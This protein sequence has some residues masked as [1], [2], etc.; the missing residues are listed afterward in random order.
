MWRIAWASVRGH[1]LRTFAT[2]LSVVFGV[3]FV[4]G[5]FVF[6]DT[7]HA[8]FEGLF[9]STVEG[10]DLVVSAADG[11]TA[12]GGAPRGV[13]AT[14]AAELT[15]RPDVADAEARYRGLAKLAREDGTALGGFGSL[16]QGVDAPRLPGAIELRDGDLPTDDGE[17]AIDAASAVELDVGVGDQ[18]M[19]LLNGPAQPYR[20]S[21]IVEP[22]SSV[23]DLAGST[24]VVFTDGVAERL[25]G[26][27]GATYIAVRAGD[28]VD[29]IELRDRMA[30]ELDAGVEVRTVDE[31][32][33]DSVSQV[34]ESLGFLTRGLLVF[35]GAALL[36]GAIIIFNTFGITVAQRTREL[37]LVQAVG[38]DNRQIMRAVLLEAGIVGSIGSAA[39]VAVGVV[40]AVALRAL[41]RLVELPLPTTGLVIEPRTA[42]LGFAVGVVVTTIAAVGPAL[43]AARRAPVDALRTASAG[44]RTVVSTARV[45]GG[46][47]CAGLACAVLIGAGLDRGGL[48]ALA[49]G[50]AALTV[51]IVLL[52]P[53]GAGPLAALVGLPV[54]AVL[55]L[56]GRLARDNAVRNPGRT[57]ATVT[58]LLI[59]LGLV[60]FMLI[61]VSSFRHSLDRAIVEQLRADYQLQAVDQIGYPS[62]VTD[63]ADEIDG[64]DLVSAAKVARGRVNGADRTVFAIDARTLP[65]VY[66]FDVVEGSLERLDD[67]GVA[68]SKQ[69]DIPLGA[70]VTVRVGSSGPASARRV[71]ALTD[72]LHLP[73]TTRV[74]QALVDA[75][76]AKEA[77]AGRPDLVAFIKL[78]PDA[79]RAGARR[80]LEQ[81]VAGQPDVRVADTAELRAQVRDQTDRLLHLVIG[82]VL[83]SVVI[84]FVGV[85]NALGLSVVERSDELGLLQAL[86]MTQGQARQMVRWESVIITTVGTVV[87]VALGTMFGWLGVRVLREEG[88]SAFSIPVA[89]IAVAVIAMLVAGVFASV[90]PARRAS[91]VDVLHAV[92]TE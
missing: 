80:E 90:V 30:A 50:A 91:H 81:V 25:Y 45:V 75:S 14:L 89:Q 64:V 26:R 42:V 71:V 77:V 4:T 37:A 18:A 6:T 79:D 65:T 86:G 15:D 51:A 54:G 87:G 40:G 49:M 5:T 17:V 85:V 52:A 39:G 10:A 11:A 12:D 48:T 84:S 2:A 24:T 55:K 8:A 38:A 32:V 60:T 29:P 74:G 69:L 82:L 58:A 34:G 31:L 78:A 56:P 53:L 21:G 28:G 36:V 83:L 35:A 7:V 57:A 19:L 27:D 1:L 20:I 44:S 43:N 9:G 16:L 13:P 62:T 92:T 3:A 66:D 47:I 76:T 46:S 68:L 22:P 41:L 88:L 33:S 63:A 23:Q 59:G 70:S 67:G 72:D 73:G 61:L